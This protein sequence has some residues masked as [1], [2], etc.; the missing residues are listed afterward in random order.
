MRLREISTPGIVMSGNRE[1]G[2]LLGT[3]RPGP[4]PPGRGWL[5][6]RR[7]G[8]RLVQLLDLPSQV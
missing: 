1:E 6:T 8:T 4:L 7:E 3:V 5:V 2:V